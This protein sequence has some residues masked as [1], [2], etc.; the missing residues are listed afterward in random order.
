[1]KSVIGAPARRLFLGLCGL[2]VFLLFM[3]GRIV[4]IDK[5]WQREL[6]RFFDLNGEG[7]FPAWVSGSLLLLTSGL[8][9]LNYHLI[10]FRK[11]GRNRWGWLALAVLF[12][13]L[14]SDEVSGIHESLT[15]IT[16]IKWVYLY[17]PGFVFVMIS[18]IFLLRD[19]EG[20]Q[21]KNLILVFAGL[22][23]FA[24][25]GLLLEWVYY[26][27]GA[28]GILDR[29]KFRLEEGLELFGAI[30][31]ITGMFDL[32]SRLLKKDRAFLKSGIL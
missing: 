11:R 7:N 12:L 32:T 8:A 25:G 26:R 22:L 9:F 23:F 29:F 27:F 24:G 10:S 19:A 16:G 31:S 4:V 28:P 15:Y 18:F 3:H 5:L 2:L 30:L 17:F 1:M 21:R 20:I 14:S 6:Y 13:F